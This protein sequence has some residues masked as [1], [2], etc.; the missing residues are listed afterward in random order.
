MSQKAMDWS[1]LST[2]KLFTQYGCQI[3]TKKIRWWSV[4]YWPT[5]IL[6]ARARYDWRIIPSTSSLVHWALAIHSPIGGVGV[7]P[8]LAGGFLKVMGLALVIIY[9][10]LGFSRTQ[11]PSIVSITP[12]YGNLQLG[13][14]SPRELS[15]FELWSSILSRQV[16][17]QGQLAVQVR[18]RVW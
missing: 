2:T 17:H 15:S 18:H 11:K 3:F 4:R 14:G 13:F 8:Y 10:R 1:I 16:I 6:S 12:M 9:F 5:L 7:I